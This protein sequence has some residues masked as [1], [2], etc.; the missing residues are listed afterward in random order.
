MTIEAKA[1]AAL[2]VAAVLGGAIWFFGFHERSVEHVKDV[3]A[4]TKAVDIQ[5]KKDDQIVKSDEAI[6]KEEAKTYEIDT[7]IPVVRAPVISVCVS[8][9]SP[10]QVAAEATDRP[11]PAGGSGLRAGDPG[12]PAK[13]VNWDSRDVVQKGADANAQ[14]KGL[15]DYIARVCPS[16]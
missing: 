15:K 5:A 1:I 10:V 12:L 8:A 11:E 4:D 7:S 14:I 2:L 13:P 3:A 16:L 6:V 9:P